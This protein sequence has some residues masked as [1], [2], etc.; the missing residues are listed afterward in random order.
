MWSLRKYII[1]KTQY[2]Q[3]FKIANTAFSHSIYSD[4]TISFSHQYVRG[5]QIYLLEGIENSLP[6][7]RKHK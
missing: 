5:I 6:H 1:V 7:T 2:L 4:G 3:V